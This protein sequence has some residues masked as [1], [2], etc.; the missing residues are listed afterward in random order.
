M[1]SAP[2]PLVAA[3]VLN[4]NGIDDTRS[5]VRSLLA[6]TWPRL[7]VHV[8]DNGSANGEADRI[9]Q[10]FGDRIELHRIADNLGFA[11]GHNGVLQRLLDDG[12]ARYIALLNNDAEAAPD[13]IEQLVATAEREP[14]VGACASLMVFR[15]DPATVENAGVVL[16][17]TGEALPRGR[18][19]PAADFQRAT[20]LLAGCG[21]ALLLRADA[22]RQCGL[23]R[24]EFFLVFEDVDL[25][26]RLC[27]AGWRCRYVPAAVVAHAL[28]RSI[29][30]VRD[31][32]FDARSIRNLSFAWLVN[33]PLPALLLSLPWLLAGWL[34]APL[35]CALLG[36]PRYA[37]TLLRGHLRALR[38]WRALLAARKALRPLRRGPWWRVF[39]MHGSSLAAYGRFLRDV[40]VLRRRAPM[41]N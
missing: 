28:G 37:A 18:G 15:S 11:A 39:A 3:I 22:L 29:D 33:M 24:R 1:S 30:K 4:W 5:A 6:Q 27:A 40:V 34:C 23:F 12:A 31:A 32:A 17:R 7:C 16:L 14:G 21:G 9:A 20:D 19:R 36:Q 25:T 2:P 10:E 13:W 8:I 35:G 26:L 38:D 41:A